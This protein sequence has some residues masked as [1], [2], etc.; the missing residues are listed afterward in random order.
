MSP[1]SGALSYVKDEETQGNDR[2]LIIARQPSPHNPD[3]NVMDHDVL[4][5]LR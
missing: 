4:C 5:L 3:L 1:D 2:P